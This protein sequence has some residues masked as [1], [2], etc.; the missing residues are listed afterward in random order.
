MRGKVNYKCPYCGE[1]EL[2]L[3]SAPVLFNKDWTI[4]QDEADRTKNYQCKSEGKITCEG[5]GKDFYYK[6][7]T[8]P[9]V[10]IGKIELTEMEV[11]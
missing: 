8:K 10:D 1:S 2:V 7:R 6:L 9:V 5:C 11:K 4:I 3:V